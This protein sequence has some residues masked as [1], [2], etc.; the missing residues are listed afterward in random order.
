MIDGAR[1]CRGLGHRASDER[2]AGRDH[3]RPMTMSSILPYLSLCIPA[4]R[5]ATQPPRVECMKVENGQGHAVPQAVPPCAAVNT[6]LNAGGQCA[7]SPPAP[8]MRHMSEHDEA[9]LDPALQVPAML[10]PPN[11]I[12][13]ALC[14]WAALTM[15]T[16][17]SSVAGTPR[18]PAR[19]P[20]DRAAAEQIAK[21]LPAAC[22]R[23]VFLSAAN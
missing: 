22:T 10:P 20:P 19:N 17:S 6:G 13:T 5:V 4:L 14:S 1:Q 7:D 16:T 2:A 3:C 21:G 11:G 18:D 12:S 9:A 23:R 8:G 15:A